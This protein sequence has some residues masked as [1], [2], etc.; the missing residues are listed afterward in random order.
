ML[1]SKHS[2]WYHIYKWCYPAFKQFS[3]WTQRPNRHKYSTSC[4]LHTG[5]TN[6]VRRALLL[7]PALVTLFLAWGASQFEMS[8]VC[9][10]R[11]LHFPPPQIL[12]LWNSPSVT[13]HVLIPLTLQLGLPDSSNMPSLCPKAHGSGP[14][15]LHTSSLSHA[16][17]MLEIIARHLLSCHPNSTAVLATELSPAERLLSRS[18]R[19]VAVQTGL[20]A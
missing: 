13:I 11:S 9:E 20:D 3:I 2:A 12:Q 8:V 6:S 17:L 15:P 1:Y 5:G 14:G 4:V 19:T 18:Q 10:S 16:L 7:P